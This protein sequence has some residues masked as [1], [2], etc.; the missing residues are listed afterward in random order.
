MLDS[1]HLALKYGDL[2]AVAPRNTIDDAFIHNLTC[3]VCAAEALHVVHVDDLPDFVA[4][5]ECESAFL[6]E[7]GSERVFYGRVPNEYPETS[8]FAL[9]QWTSLERVRESA[10][11][12]REPT[13]DVDIASR[14]AFE[15]QPEEDDTFDA[16][17]RAVGV[18]LASEPIEEPPDVPV[19]LD[20][21]PQLELEAEAPAPVAPE[22]DTPEPEVEAEEEESPPDLPYGPPLT[23]PPPGMRY[24][25]VIRGSEVVFPSNDCAHCMQSPVKGRLAVIGALP[26]GQKVGQ[27][28]KSTFNI[29]LCA[30]CAKRAA[31]LSE[32]AKNARLQA[33]LLSA[34]F[35]LILVI[36]ALGVGF[37]N[38][39][40][41][42]LPG[43]IIL[44]ILGIIGYTLP[45]MILLGR[46][47]KHPPPPDAVYVRS[48]LLVPR[49]TQGLETAFE[50]RNEVYAN[51]FYEGNEA[52]ALGRL[53]SVKDRAAQPDLPG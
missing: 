6:L 20:E 45:A 37:I 50:W 22:P 16:L 26:N 43:L 9:E 28:K 13:E 46:V 10:A 29:P 48:T 12:E 4:C 33:H 36:G 52:N 5:G 21:T 17:S 32:D 24:R 49:E 23:D 35:A 3:A 41:M 47:G 25:V 7:D 19:P 44:L 8:T 14:L 34:I 31:E 51:E 42:G 30:D 2:T 11:D 53:I 39:Q 15:V 40:Q 1:V 27:R 18:P 38:T